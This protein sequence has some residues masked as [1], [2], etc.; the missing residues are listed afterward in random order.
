[1]LE[2]AALLA[3][4]LNARAL[5][6]EGVAGQRVLRALVALGGEVADR[7]ADADAGAGPGGGD[8]GLDA[9]AERDEQKAAGDHGAADD[10][11]DAA[12][13]LGVDLGALLVGGGAGESEAGLGVDDAQ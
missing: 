5:V 12:V 1:M 8:G 9:V 13:A 7:L 4:E 10:L 3:G 11:G 6:L 2:V